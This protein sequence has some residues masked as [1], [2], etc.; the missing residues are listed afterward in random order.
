MATSVLLCGYENR[1]LSSADKT[2]IETAEITFLRKAAGHNLRVEISNLAILNELQILNTG[3][4]T[5]CRKTIGMDTSH[6][7]THAE[8]HDM[9]W[10]TN[11]RD[12]ETSDTQGDGGRTT[13]EGSYMIGTEISV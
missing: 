3:E 10:L 6:E 2:K 4:W 1:A 5:S 9:R 11:L 12:A 7:W 8:Q 13:D